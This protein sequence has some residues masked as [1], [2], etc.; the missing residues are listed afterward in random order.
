MAAVGSALMPIA[1]RILGGFNNIGASISAFVT[2]HGP[3]IAAW[4]EG[5]GKAFDWVAATVMEVAAAVVQAGVDLMA[6]IQTWEIYHTVV[7]A[8]AAAWGYL[9]DIGIEVFEKL[10]IVYRNF[11]TV[12]GIV[13]LMAKEKVIN[14]GEAIGWFVANSGQ[15]LEWFGR[16]WVALFADAFNAAL[17]VVKN[18]A[19]N[20]WNNMKALWD[21]L[22][23]GG[24]KKLEL[25]WTPLMDGFKKTME[26]LPDIAA[27]VFSSLQGEIDALGDQMAAA[28][29][30]RAAA[31]KKADAPAKAAT[32]AAG[33]AKKKADDGAMKKAAEAKF[34]GLEAFGKDLQ[35]A[36]LGKGG[37]GKRTADG[38]D[39]LVAEQKGL[40][41]DV[42]KLAG[43]PATA[44]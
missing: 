19:S 16:N 3:L 15:L 14:M 44:G 27:P 41:K 42:Q 6:E 35:T 29:G 37:D 20:V 25:S 32:A 38:V 34:V 10:G 8:L 24:T 40:R 13:F 28:E 11:G 33:D 17:A 31:M 39:K 5:V 23:S 43:M 7:D 1:S 26:D 4:S 12:A 18:F 36:I 2:Q 21:F 30:K 22:A 9:R